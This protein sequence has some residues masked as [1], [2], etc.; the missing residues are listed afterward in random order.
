M[1]GLCSFVCIKE[2]TKCIQPKKKK[3]KECQTQSLSSEK[4]GLKRKL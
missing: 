1:K 4:K 2:Q 3:G